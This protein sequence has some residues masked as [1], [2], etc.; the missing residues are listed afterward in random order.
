MRF[1]IPTVLIAC[2]VAVQPVPAQVRFATP[3]V[4]PSFGPFPTGIVAGDFNNDGIPDLMVGD[5]AASAAEVSLGIGDGTF[6]D[7][8]GAC[9]DSDPV[10]VVGVGKFDG[11]NLDAL[12]NDYLGEDAVVCLGDGNGQF[13]SE[14]LLPINPSNIVNAFAAADFN[15]DGNE[16][17]AL[18]TGQNTNGAN[19]RIG[20]L[21]VYLGNGDGSFRGPQVRTAPTNAIAIATGDFNGDGKPDLVILGDDYSDFGAYVAV[22]LGTGL[23]HFSSP[24]KFRIPKNH[25]KFGRPTAL[26]VGDFNGDH[27][28]DVAITIPVSDSNDPGSVVVLF[29][30]GAGT[31]RKGTVANA[32]TDPLSIAVADFNGDGILDLV[33]SNDP[34]Y[35]AC[36]NPGAISVLVG[37]GDGTFQAPQTF[38]TGGEL[39]FLTVADFNG[40]GKPDVATA[41]GDSRSISVLL[42]TTPW[43]KKK[44]RQLPTGPTRP[45]Q[46]HRAD[47]GD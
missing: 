10:S 8:A 45:D 26:A 4:F 13:L 39:P 46:V 9:S 20:E 5:L 38:A 36:G 11:K 29:G 42:N 47:Q 3:I 33:V 12:A 18:V 40:D 14:T 41:N 22:L 43:P 16:D 1:V 19:L 35:P 37:A 34:C 31:L 21:Y 6:G 7:W 24:I 28:L 2:S 17:L 32:G 25:G 15:G 27:N 30:N 44:Q 23:G